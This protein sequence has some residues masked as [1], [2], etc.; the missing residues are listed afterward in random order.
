MIDI[1]LLLALIV[2]GYVVGQ[3]LEK[4]H[5]RSIEMREKDFINLATTANK[6][7]PGELPEEVRTELVQGACVISV[8]YFKRFVARL[9][10]L[11]GGN[12]RSYETLV[13]RARREAILRLKESAADASQVVN[14][15][16]ETSS[17][18]KGRRNQ[19]GSVEVHAYAT[20]IYY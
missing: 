4:K 13:D 5:Y 1:Y 10:Q 2:T 9:R 17:I 3:Y 19:I 20:A 15:R 12:I 6:S 8:D 14:L 18:T 16:I 11:F 7:V